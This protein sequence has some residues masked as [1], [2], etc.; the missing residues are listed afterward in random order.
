MIR[1]I[2]FLRYICLLLLISSIGLADSYVSDKGELIVDGE[3]FFVM[4]FFADS[5]SSSY[6]DKIETIDSLSAGGFNVIKTSAM[7]EKWQRD[8]HFRIAKERG[9]KLI[10]DGAQN[11]EWKD[12]HLNVMNTCRNK[13][14][15]LG[16]YIVD[17]SHGI[18]P[19]TIKM[20]HEQAKAID[21]THITTHSM[22]LSCWNDYGSDHIRKRIPYCDILQMQSYPVGKEPIDQVYRDMRTTLAAVEP[23]NKSVLVDLQL[24]NWQLTGHDW[25]R[26]PTPKE[27][28]LMTWL[29][30]VAGVDGYLYYS[31][32]DRLAEPDQSL[33]FSQPELWKTVKA[34]AAKVNEIKPV[35]LN[36]IKFITFNP[37]ANC[38][39]GHW[40]S[41][42]HSTIIIIN[43]HQTDSLSLTI[44]VVKEHDQIKGLFDKDY[45]SFDIDNGFLKGF[46]DPMS[47]EFIRLLPSNTKIHDKQLPTD[48]DFNIFP[49]PGNSR[50]NLS[51]NAEVNTPYQINIYSLQ[52]RLVKKIAGKKTSIGNTS[53]AIPF[54]E[55]PAGVYFI[56]IEMGGELLVRKWTYLP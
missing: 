20:Y 33:C 11:N 47:I 21:S 22:A 31:Y 35:L 55:N 40:I 8:N 56:R 6:S 25:G 46:I 51:L 19:D 16:W 36:H 24:F 13:E 54:Y 49:N 5:Y 30:I 45:G 48:F 32:Y 9:M 18:D 3:P 34:T 1:L 27:A 38:Y 15:L 44:P 53:L 28:Q 41:D 10:Y 52:G 37:K 14:A 4:G 50:L 26:W 17:D 42:E 29:A 39:Y 2:I 23:Y 43:T 12:F 7:G